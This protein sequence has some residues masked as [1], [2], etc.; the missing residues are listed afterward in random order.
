[1]N[2]SSTKEPQTEIKHLSLGVP[3]PYSN[4]WCIQTTNTPRIATT[5]ECHYGPLYGVP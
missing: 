4:T 3:G 5:N 1:M 2:V